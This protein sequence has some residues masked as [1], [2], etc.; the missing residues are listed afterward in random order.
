MERLTRRNLL[1]AAGAFAGGSALASGR[2]M[3]ASDPFALGGRQD[4]N[5]AEILAL[6]RKWL[7]TCRQ[8]DGVDDDV[9]DDDSEWNALCDRQWHIEDSIFE[10]R[11]GA[12]GLSVKT[13][14]HLYREFA[15]WTPLN[16]QIKLDGDETG[17]HRSWV[18]SILRDAA[19]AVPEIGEC[20][21]AII[22]EDA[23]LIAADMVVEWT[24]RY[25]GL[26]SPLHPFERPEWRQEK[27]RQ[28]TAKRELIANTEAKT[29]RGRAIKARHAGGAA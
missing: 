12:A 6:F 7:D 18:T 1:G 24:V 9:S 20:A 17:I 16:E 21:A 5:D 22:H 27:R 29:E 3:S 13:F 15:N 23:D 28:L 25:G 26:D 19:A 11:G 2:S 10:C 8:L 4:D 14:L